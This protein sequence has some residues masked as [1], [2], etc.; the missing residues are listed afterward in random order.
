MLGVFLSPRYAEDHFV[1]LTY[2][3]PGDGGSSLALAR[4]KL[5]LDEG[6]ATPPSYTINWARPYCTLCQQRL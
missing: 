1:Y 6:S 3:E 2:S 4:A 5:G